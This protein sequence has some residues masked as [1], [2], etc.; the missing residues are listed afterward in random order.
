M[1]IAI[2]VQK[3]IHKAKLQKEKFTMIRFN[4]E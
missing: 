1:I 2:E 4:P 3:I